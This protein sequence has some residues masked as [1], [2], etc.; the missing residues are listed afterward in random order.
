MGL[1]GRR[2]RGRV[3]ETTDEADVGRDELGEDLTDENGTSTPGTSAE[4]DHPGTDGPYDRADVPGRQ[5]RLDLGSLWMAGV[6]G[7]QL[8]L[9]IDQVTSELSA[10]TVL[11][12]ES[13]M[14]V[15]AFAAPKRSG[16]WDEIRTEIA[17]AV[18][19]Q[20]GTA[21]PTEGPL[22]T[23]LMARL[24]AR[25]NDG[26]VSFQPARFIGVDG[27]RWFLRAV[28]TGAAAADAGLAEPLLAVIGS[29]VVVRGEEAMAPRDLLPLRLPDEGV[30]DTAEAQAP[31][32]DDFSPFERG[33]EI[34]EIR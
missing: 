2:R 4:D 11:L 34:T 24:P 30:E 22:G 8:Q 12:G 26:A 5:G 1:F 19:A 20:G 27:P 28:I 13:T 3:G 6:P 16:I 29:T 7:M 31:A 23:E 25:G 9:E 15:Q 18:A 17:Q 33:P 14:Q 10:A 32:V 21:E